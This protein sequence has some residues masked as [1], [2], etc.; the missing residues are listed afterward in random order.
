M[1]AP[2]SASLSSSSLEHHI[3]VDAELDSSSDA[4]APSPSLLSLSSSSAS[5]VPS[6]PSASSSASSVPSSSVPSSSVPSSSSASSV[7]SSSSAFSA[8]ASS[9]SA[10]SLTLQHN[11]ADALR[12]LSENGAVSGTQ[13]LVLALRMV[14]R[15]GVAWQDHRL[16]S[17]LRVVP[18]AASGHQLRDWLLIS[19]PHARVASDKADRLLRSLIRHRYF[20][21]V[22]TSATTPLSFS[23]SSSPADSPQGA[24]ALE[25]SSL[26]S[27]LSSTTG[28]GTAARVY[29]PNSEVHTRSSDYV[30]SCCTHSICVACHLHCETFL[31][32]CV[33]V[34]ICVCSFIAARCGS[35]LSCCVLSQR[36]SLTELYFFVLVI[37][38]HDFRSLS[39]HP[40]SAIGSPLLLSLSLCLSSLSFSLFVSLR[41]S[42]CVFSS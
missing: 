20:L 18:H 37:L 3:D 1:S 40:C 42:L 29:V 34:C 7:P 31:S 35:S 16:H 22:G 41:L 25:S 33:G 14:S 5:S 36:V 39:L 27:A 24:F 4:G 8:S 26:S 28:D 19:V 17:Q 2:E 21:R 32:V 13:E 6:V 38:S 23:P 10:S 15:H 12:V 9:S 11:L 30:L